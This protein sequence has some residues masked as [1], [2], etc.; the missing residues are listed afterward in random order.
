MNFGKKLKQLGFEKSECRN[1]PL[2]EYD[3][4]KMYD[5]TIIYYI[6]KGYW[7]LNNTGSQLVMM[8]C[9]A[10]ANFKNIKKIIKLMER[11]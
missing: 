4:Y 6:S 2:D 1:G 7:A 5:I 10:K 11:L 3:F 9:T 8:P